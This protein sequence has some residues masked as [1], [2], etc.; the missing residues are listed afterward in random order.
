[1]VVCLTKNHQAQFQLKSHVGL[2]CV[3]QGPKVACICIPHDNT[4]VTAVKTKRKK[5]RNI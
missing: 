5:Q 4:R 3:V 2:G 1:V